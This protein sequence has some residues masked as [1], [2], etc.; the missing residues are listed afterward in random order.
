MSKAVKYI[1][2]L[3]LLAACISC[4]K[5]EDKL[6][7]SFTFQDSS[8]KEPLN[9]KEFIL[10]QVASNGDE[11]RTGVAVTKENG[12]AEFLV[13][14]IVSNGR[15]YFRMVV[16]SI[17]DSSNNHFWYYSNSTI[18][19]GSELLN[20]EPVYISPCGAFT[21][22][23][24]INDYQKFDTLYASIGATTK[25]F[26]AGIP[27]IKFDSIIPHKFYNVQYSAY[28][29]GKYSDTAVAQGFAANQFYL[30]G[31]NGFSTLVLDLDSLSY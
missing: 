22:D 23:V 31:T 20:L 21:I 4:Y 25:K 10:Y 18:Q 29:N 28:N 9:N 8:T 27:R 14:E 24:D 5:P 7:V 17:R 26:Y 2:F 11:T 12:T 15:Y 30:F 3:G 13:N 6:T 16:P 19:A 1:W